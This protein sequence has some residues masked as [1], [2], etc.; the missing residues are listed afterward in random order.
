MRL[1]FTISFLWSH[2][3]NLI[4]GLRKIHDRQFCRASRLKNLTRKYKIDNQVSILPNGRLKLEII[5]KRKN[6]LT[7]FLAINIKL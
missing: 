3:V 4:K 2:G 5:L 1:K 7:E 6:N